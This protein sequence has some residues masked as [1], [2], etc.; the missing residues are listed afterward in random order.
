VGDD[1]S[2]A[3]RMAAIVDTYDAMTSHRPYRQAMA[4]SL[5]LNQLVAEGTN[6]YDPQLVAS[7]VQAIGPFPVGSLVLLESGHLAVVD[8][9]NHND[10][11]APVVRVIYHAGRR[12]YVT[13][14]RVDLSR[15]FGNHYGFIVRAEQYETWGLSPLRWEP[16]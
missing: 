10:W 1:I 16:V 7:F 8:E 11:L 12:Q 4:P 14:A 5:V 6:H 2:S 13:P 3:G 15:K 9:V